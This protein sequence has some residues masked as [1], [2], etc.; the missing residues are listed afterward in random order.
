[1]PVLMRPVPNLFFF[2]K[3]VQ[4]LPKIVTDEIRHEG[5]IC[6]A[7]RVYLTVNQ[8]CSKTHC[9]IR[10][11]C[12]YILNGRKIVSV[13]IENALSQAQIHWKRLHTI[14]LFLSLIHMESRAYTHVHVKLSTSVHNEMSSINFQIIAQT[15]V[16]GR[17]VDFRRISTPR[18]S[19]ICL[20]PMRFLT[21]ILSIEL[22]W[23]F[24][25]ILI[26]HGIEQ[27]LRQSP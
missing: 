1:M 5:M 20:F 19:A 12:E 24:H 23:D 4:N 11:C 14:R 22:I 17:V 2:S 6:D 26:R 25:S 13:C 18:R 9:C 10:T 7:F 3:I 27:I 15:F 21:R 8:Q 16:W